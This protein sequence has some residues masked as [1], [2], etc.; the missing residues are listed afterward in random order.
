MK[1][2]KV[3]ILSLVAIAFAALVSI[4]ST[5]RDQDHETLASRIKS[6]APEAGLV[7]G[8]EEGRLAEFWLPGD[9]GSGR[10]APDR[11]KFSRKFA[12]SGSDSVELTVRQGDVAQPGADDTITERTELDSGKYPLCGK[13]ICYGFSFLIPKDFPIRDVRLVISQIK[14]S[15]GNGPLVAQR[16][17]DGKHTLVIESHGKKS[18][19]TLPNIR[20]GEWHDMIYRVRYSEAN[21]VVEVTMDGKRVANYK[22]PLGKETPGNL[23]Y[24]KIGLYRDKIPE[25]MT[26]Y[27]DNYRTGQTPQ[28]VDPAQFPG[29]PAS[30]SAR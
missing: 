1:T 13:E 28:A 11:V 27:F 10:F 18:R 3:K 9:F 8:F 16:F 7:D 23:F 22:G 15:D 21:G 20:K 14:Q 2:N 17:R 29:G 4:T 5:A 6:Y 30:R 12:R 24:H 19:F 25:P 26:I